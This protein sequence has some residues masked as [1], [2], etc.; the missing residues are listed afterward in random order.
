M[1]FAWPKTLMHPKLLLKKWFGSA[2]HTKRI[3]N[4]RPKYV[5]FESALKDSGRLC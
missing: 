1:H 3:E 5:G 4:Y 2:Q